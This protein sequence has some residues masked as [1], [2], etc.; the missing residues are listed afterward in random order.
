MDIET[1]GM[2]PRKRFLETLLGGKPDRFPSFD[3]DPAEE[4]LGRW[5]GEGFPEEET[6]AGFFRLEPHHSA[7][8]DL[9]SRPRYVGPPEPLDDEVFFARRYDP[10]D[11]ERFAED[12]VEK[13]A[14]A[15]REGR[16]VS[17][18][19]W[20]GG[21]LQM[22]GVGD[23]ESMREAMYA[24]VERPRMIERI[25]GR[26]IDFYCAC[27]ERVL[28]RVRV[29]YASFYE[30]IASNEGPVISPAMF[31]RYAAPGYRKVLGL[32][33]RHGVPLRVLCTTGGDLTRLF[34]SLLEAGINGLWISSISAAGVKYPALRRAFGKELA[35]IGGIDA[36][37]LRRSE[38]EILRAVDETVPGLLEEGRYLPCLDD[39]PRVDVSFARYVFF[40]RHLE[41]YASKD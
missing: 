19:A 30:P 41:K 36:E 18:D 20:A 17:V 31:E 38:E 6:F 21:F 14:L 9:R 15:R 32:L 1:T 11:P 40:R 3:L 13:C 35:L 24:L 29:D 22:L 26:T 2:S 27:L 39:R 12:Y 8:L 33:E 25:V 37:A 34:P 4:T 16:V 10:G 28:S 23:W 5:R 7:G